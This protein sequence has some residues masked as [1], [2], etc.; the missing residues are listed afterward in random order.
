MTLTILVLLVMLAVGI[1]FSPDH[2]AFIAFEQRRTAWHA[3]CDRY[4]NQPIRDAEGRWCN[5]ELAAMLAEGKARGWA[6]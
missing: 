2:Q 6:R 4:R 1:Y 3:S 5:E